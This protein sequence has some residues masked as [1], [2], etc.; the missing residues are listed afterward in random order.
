VVS[1]R[2]CQAAWIR[3]AGVLV[4]PILTATVH[5][6]GGHF[7][8]GLKRL[9]STIVEVFSSITVQATTQTSA[10]IIDSL[11]NGLGATVRQAPADGRVGLHR[12]LAVRLALP[13]DATIMHIDLDHLLRWI[14]TDRGELEAIVREAA[15]WDLLVVGRT[16]E[17]MAACPRRLRDT[18]AIINHVYKLITGHRRDVMFGVRL[19]SPRCAVSIVEECTEDSVG[20][21][22]EW[23]LHAEG[24]GF[25]VAYAEANGLSYR[26][27]ADFD[28]TADALDTSPAQWIARINIMNDHAQAMRRF[29][30]G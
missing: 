28:A 5:D 18:E 14:E 10:A 3:L 12:R 26:T 25:A 13:A 4:R 2:Q 21:D 24:A 8:P 7:L 22:V 27:R 1:R 15:A 6:P 11:V 9:G 17:A 30:D 16:A 23:P 20:N 19:M 29:A